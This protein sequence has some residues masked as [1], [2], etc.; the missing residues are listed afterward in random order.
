MCTYRK[1]LKYVSGTNECDKWYSNNLIF[2]TWV[3]IK[4]SNIR[5]SPR[6]VD[7]W[8]SFPVSSRPITRLPTTASLC[9]HCKNSSSNLIQHCHHLHRLNGCLVQ[10]DNSLLRRQ[11]HL[12]DD[13][14]EILLI[15]N[16]NTHFV[17]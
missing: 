11:N 12:Q 9:S 7:H 3:F 1:V 13:M 10:H 8:A 5:R 14:F 17:A 6:V 2:G 4:Y 16:N 15:L